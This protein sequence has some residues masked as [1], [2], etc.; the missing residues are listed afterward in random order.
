MDM[1]NTA[2]VQSPDNLEE[3][4]FTNDF[5]L[6]DDDGVSIHPAAEGSVLM[7]MALERRMTDPDYQGEGEESETQP[8][9]SDAQRDA[10][11][12]EH[13]AEF[14]RLTTEDAMLEDG[15]DD[16]TESGFPLEE[17]SPVVEVDADAGD[18][19]LFG[20]GDRTQSDMG[21]DEWILEEILGRR[22]SKGP[23]SVSARIDE[24]AA[25]YDEGVLS[26]HQPIGQDQWE[27]KC[28][29]KYYREPTW[30]T[31]ALLQEEGFG[32]VVEKFDS[33]H[34][35]VG[36]VE[37][38]V[39]KAIPERPDLNLI[40]KGLPSL[41]EELSMQFYFY[42]RYEVVGMA[43]IA[44]PLRVKQFLTAWK[45]NRDSRLYFVYHGTRA[46][47]IP[48]IA[49]HSLVRPGRCGVAVANG[50]AHGVGIYSSKSL[51]Q[52]LA[53]LS[54]RDPP[55]VLLCAAI[56]PRQEDLVIRSGDVRVFFSEACIVPLYCVCFR[57]E[58]VDGGKLQRR[59]IDVLPPE[60]SL[61][62]L[63]QW[64]R[65]TGSE[66]CN[67]RSTQEC[68][69]Q[70]GKVRA[71]HISELHPTVQSIPSKL[72]KDLTKHGHPT[73]RMLKQMPRYVRELLKTGDP[74]ER[75][76]PTIG[77]VPLQ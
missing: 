44:Q 40:L 23:K 22:K 18:E 53:Y 8:W 3:S 70:Y 2:A 59:S 34:V 66:D 60:W 55:C 43:N 56:D 67:I 57:R 71:G 11:W 51:C 30:E 50:S 62:Q 26:A 77:F 61:K 72:T 28:K 38:K 19:D 48:S 12:A 14:E 15:P 75:K 7:A 76:P 49:R 39:P 73:K 21:E 37:L 29:W 46:K 13:G 5:V 25:A 10:F 68:R 32:G 54:Y 9:E 69:R 35:P 63:W 16:F 4:D 1:R 17:S 27:Y 20:Q 47:N 45:H 31:K 24:V 65:V 64:L 42:Y 33:E 58:D 41:V 74:I 36:K 6:L 52:P